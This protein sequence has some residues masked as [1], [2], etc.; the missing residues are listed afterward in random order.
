MICP[1]RVGVK[2]EYQYIGTSSIE[3]RVSSDKY[4]QVA[5]H[6]L[7]EEC[8]KEDCPFYNYAGGCDRIGD[9]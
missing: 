9:K 8:D 6:A 2:Y 4:I 7:F 5:Q 1:F 3:D